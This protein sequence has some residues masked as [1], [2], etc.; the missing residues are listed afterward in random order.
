MTRAPFQVLVLPFCI[1]QESL[2]VLILQ[3]QDEAYW[4][5]CAGGGEDGESV[6][7]A[8]NRELMEETG[9]AGCIESLDSRTSVHV[10]AI[11][12]EFIWGP[13]VHVIP[14]HSFAVRLPTQELPQLSEE[15]NAGMW[16]TASEAF[17]KLQ[18]DSNKTAL[19]ELQ[20][21]LSQSGP[22]S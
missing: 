7:D 10:L 18:W 20:T 22:E 3:R 16:C 1:D 21:R 11:A 19:W 13:D 17:E 14:E 12:P 15:H 9:L 4:Q 2:K 5:F 8:A 6:V